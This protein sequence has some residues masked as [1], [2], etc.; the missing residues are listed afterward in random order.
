MESRR[1]DARPPWTTS[2]IRSSC[3]RITSW[4]TNL[5]AQHG[6]VE[7]EVQLRGGLLV[8]PPGAPLRVCTIRLGAL[9]VDHPGGE[10]RPVRSARVWSRPGTTRV[11]Q[12]AQVEGRTFVAEA[13]D[14]AGRQDVA[15]VREG[16]LPGPPDHSSLSTTAASVTAYN[17]SSA[18]RSIN[19]M[20]TSPDSTADCPLRR[21]VE[22]RRHG[23]SGWA[24]PAGAA[25]LLSASRS[26]R[27]IAAEFDISV[28]S[29]RD[30]CRG[31]GAIRYPGA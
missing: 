28:P 7:D 22:R 25:G 10:H 5:A 26:R 30:A 15:V 12:L 17:C 23:P 9:L 6:L 31:L 27:R 21:P 14:A 24:S 2:R 29:R 1:S 8:R 3:S 4:T 16:Q 11:F 20:L 18:R 13:L 19:L